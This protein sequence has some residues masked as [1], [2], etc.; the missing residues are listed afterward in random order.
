MA[1]RR[2]KPGKNPSRETH[3]SSPRSSFA[4]LPKISPARSV[5]RVELSSVANLHNPGAAAPAELGPE[6]L[7]HDPISAATLRLDVQ[8]PNIHRIG[9]GYAEPQQRW[10][11]IRAAR[12]ARGATPHLQPASAE[13]GGS[14]RRSRPTRLR[15]CGSSIEHRQ[16]H[17][18][19]PHHRADLDRGGRRRRPRVLRGVHRIR[20]R[21]RR[22]LGARPCA[23]QA[24]APGLAVVALAQADPRWTWRSS[25]AWPTARRRSDRVV[26]LGGGLRPRR[27]VPVVGPDARPAAGAA[28]V[29]P[30]TAP[31]VGGPGMPPDAAAVARCPRRAGR[32]PRSAAP[33][34]DHHVGRRPGPV[35]TRRRSP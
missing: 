6:P 21:A 32:R 16:S 18:G 12:T 15:R 1:T 27:A 8:A 5:Q 28:P 35:D 4:D 24:A 2:P 7:R 11:H 20:S 26:G 30:G 19:R 25:S 22:Q 13:A 9:L 17:R 31:A 34:P 14:R 29:H 23:A 33:I 3:V 10:T